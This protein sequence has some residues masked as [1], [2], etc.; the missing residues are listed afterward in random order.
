MGEIHAI[1][2]KFKG[3]QN[4]FSLLIFSIKIILFNIISNYTGFNILLFI[5]IKYI[6]IKK[7][8]LFIFKALFVD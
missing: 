1:S 2:S 5:K 3:S 6:F 8:V 7:I 4:I